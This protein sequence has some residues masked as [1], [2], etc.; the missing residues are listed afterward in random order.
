MWKIN[1]SWTAEPNILLTAPFLQGIFLYFWK[2][3]GICAPYAILFS[4]ITYYVPYTFHAI[5]LWT[6][7]LC[8]IF[9]NTKPLWLTYWGEVVLGLWNTAN[10]MFVSCVE[11]HGIAYARLLVYRKTLFYSYYRAIQSAI[12]IVCNFNVKI[13]LGL[14]KLEYLAL[15][16]FPSSFSNIIALFWH[17]HLNPKQSILKTHTRKAK[18]TEVFY[19]H[20]YEHM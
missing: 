1:R 2:K 17:L 16:I 15:F 10:S 19:F 4:V 18:K 13:I 3:T 11:D 8:W 5:Y 12:K 14:I 9:I 20:I 7:K 6:L